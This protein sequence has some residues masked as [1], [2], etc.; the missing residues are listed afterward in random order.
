MDQK[1]FKISNNNHSGFEHVF[2]GEKKLG[3]VQVRNFLFSRKSSFPPPRVSTTGSTSTILRSKARCMNGMR[4]L[5]FIVSGLVRVSF[6]GVH[7]DL[8]VFVR[9]GE[10]PRALVYLQVNYLGH[11]ESPKLGNHGTGLSFTFK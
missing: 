11:W 1:E 10:L 4:C 3:K 2:L 6:E 7:P 9:A 8:N 5:G